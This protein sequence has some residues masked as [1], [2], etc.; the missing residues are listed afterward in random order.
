M[1][2]I[3]QQKSKNPRQLRAIGGFLDNIGQ[4][5]SKIWWYMW[6]LTTDPSIMSDDN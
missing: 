6:T 4:H 1:D 2:Y 3:G 5:K